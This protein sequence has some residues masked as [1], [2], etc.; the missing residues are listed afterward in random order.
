MNI[1]FA[2]EYEKLQLLLSQGQFELFFPSDDATSDI[3]LVYL[4]NDAAESFLVFKNARLTGKY[5][6]DY[7]GD[8]EATLEQISEKQALDATVKP[9]ATLEQISEKHMLDAAVKL[10]ASSAPTTGEYAL[11]VHQGDTVCTLFFQ[12]LALE[13]HLFNYGKTGHFWVK[14]YE[15]LRQLEYRIA[16]LRD[17]RVYLGEKY[18]SPEE[19]ALSYLAEFPPLNFC[20]YPA[21]P[22]K[23]LVPGCPWWQVSEEA[24]AKMYALAE[25]SGDQSLKNWLKVYARFPKKMIA[26]YIARMLHTQKHAA[27]VDLL[28]QKLTTAAAVYDDRV[29]SAE[30]EMRFKK[31][32]EKAENRKKELEHSGKRVEMLIEEPFLYAKDSIE[33]KIHLMIWKK[34]G[35]DRKVDV[36]TFT[37]E[38][39]Q[40]EH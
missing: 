35:K 12:E 10:E 21:V 6:P 26:R 5:M 3:R 36:E 19:V 4:M 8:L 17:K 9:E 38:D 29:F 20:C 22:D 32:K 7:E 2:R 16:V 13:T 33:Y 39:I 27:V 28:T 30:E 14:G 23:Y 1:D 18:C 34:D 37:E 25:E 40:K 24:W 11:I 31:I 15:Y